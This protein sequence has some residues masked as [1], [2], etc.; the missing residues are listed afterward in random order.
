LPLLKIC[1]IDLQQPRQLIRSLQQYA[2]VLARQTEAEA[3]SNEPEEP[4]EVEAEED[5][6]EEIATLGHDELMKRSPT[7][8]RTAKKSNVE[9]T[10][11]ES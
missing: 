5:E 8:R 9:D 2:E 11:S 4:T 6:E 7:Y 3:I 10:D 1:I